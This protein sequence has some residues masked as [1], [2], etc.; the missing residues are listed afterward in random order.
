MLDDFGKDTLTYEKL[1]KAVG[2]VCD[3]ITDE[4]CYNFF[5]AARYKTD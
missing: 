5:K 1:W 2:H 3:P 4:E